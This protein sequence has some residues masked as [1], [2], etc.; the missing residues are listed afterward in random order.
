VRARGQRLE[1][2][3]VVLAELIVEELISHTDQRLLGVYPGWQ[4]RPGICRSEEDGVDGK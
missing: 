2:V 4:Q 3:D 1:L